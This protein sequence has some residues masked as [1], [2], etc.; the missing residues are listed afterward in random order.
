MDTGEVPSSQESD[1]SLAGEVASET[2]GRL[3]LDMT[4][5]SRAQELVCHGVGEKE[6]EE[7]SARTVPGSGSCKEGGWGCPLRQGSQGSRLPGGQVF[8]LG[9]GGDRLQEQPEQRR[10]EEKGHMRKPHEEPW[11]VLESSGKWD[12]AWS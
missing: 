6:A 9:Q 5:R 4:G 3:T 1:G 7:G 2:E 10:R 11:N 12:C 8:V